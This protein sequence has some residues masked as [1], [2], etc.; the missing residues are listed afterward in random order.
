MP[1]DLVPTLSKRI[2]NWRIGTNPPRKNKARNAKSEHTSDG[3]RYQRTS[4]MNVVRQTSVVRILENAIDLA[5]GATVE[6]DKGH[7]FLVTL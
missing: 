4:L 7:V 2:V 5:L 1:R 6:A 3:L